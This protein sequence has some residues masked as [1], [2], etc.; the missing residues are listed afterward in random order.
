[1]GVPYGKTCLNHLT[2]NTVHGGT[3]SAGTCVMVCELPVQPLLPVQAP[4]PQAVGHIF[5][6]KSVLRGLTF[7]PSTH[8]TAQQTFQYSLLFELLCTIVS[9][10]TFLIRVNG[11]PS[12]SEWIP[13]PTQTCTMEKKKTPKKQCC[14][15]CPLGYIIY[16]LVCHALL[17]HYSF[18]KATQCTELC[19]THRSTF[20][21]VILY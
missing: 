1:M 21:N 10:N 3:C 13:K 4:W 12:A 11:V 8:V 19:A 16:L 6:P 14:N 17:Q 18:S 7:S 2:W 5:L 9:I 20:N 15:T